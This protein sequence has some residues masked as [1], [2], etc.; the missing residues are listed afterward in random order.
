MRRSRPS[1]DRHTSDGMH[2]DRC[3]SMPTVI[4]VRQDR[5]GEKS[6]H[7]MWFNDLL[8]ASLWNVRY[9]WKRCVHH[10]DWGSLSYKTGHFGWATHK[11][12]STPAPTG[13]LW[14]AI[15]RYIQ[16]IV[17]L[18]KGSTLSEMWAFPPLWLGQEIGQILIFKQPTRFCFSWPPSHTNSRG[19]IKTVWR[20]SDQIQLR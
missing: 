16:R 13:R 6:L 1:T 15:D 18:S 17:I 7:E 12:I 3:Y 20:M 11:G 5:N 8:E 4:L 19:Y 14:R 2:F 9:N 10:R